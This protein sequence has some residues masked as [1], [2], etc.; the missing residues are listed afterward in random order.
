VTR[1]R[2]HVWPFL[3]LPGSLLLRDWLAI[4][5]GHHILAWRGLTDREL[6]HELEHVRQ[7]ARH[8]LAFP[9]AYGLAALRERRAGRRW[10]HDNRFEVEARAAADQAGTRPTRR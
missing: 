6:K 7:W 10:Y 3:R 5:L 1:H 2:V 8:G 9:I 4:T